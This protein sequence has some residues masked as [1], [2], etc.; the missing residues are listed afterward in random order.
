MLPVWFTNYM[1]TNNLKSI[2]DQK[3]DPADGG[4]KLK[5]TNNNMDN[6][7]L[8]EGYSVPDSSTG[9]MRFKQGENRFRVLSSAITGWEWWVAD[10]ED[11]NK[12]SP[13]RVKKESD[14]PAEV[15]AATRLDDKDKHFW[16]FIVW[17]YQ[18]N[19]LQILEVTQK[20]IQ[21][22]LLALTKDEDW[23]KPQNY[24]IVVT[25][26]GEGLETDYQVQPKPH[27]PLDEEVGNLY[28]QV[29]IDLDALYDNKDPFSPDDRSL[30]DEFEQALSN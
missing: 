5:I 12:R 30:M 7:F 10:P 1:G 17:N 22:S 13:K 18:E 15:K 20:G 19:R 6:P 29:I 11:K 27:R 8:P 25:R 26:E 23:G 9:Y 16:A 4:T 3:N 14:V 21:K 24:D 28:S 2:T